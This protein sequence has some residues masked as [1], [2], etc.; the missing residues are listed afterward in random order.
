MY[1]LGDIEELC[2]S[3]KV[4]IDQTGSAKSKLKRIMV[5]KAGESQLLRAYRNKEILLR[6]DATRLLPTDRPYILS[7][8]A[9]S[10]HSFNF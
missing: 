3:Y 9:C 2:T 8:F 5:D 10:I 4:R 7:P 1:L 6:A